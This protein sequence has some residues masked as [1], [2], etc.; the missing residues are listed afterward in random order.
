MSDKLQKQIQQNL[1]HL[2]GNLKDNFLNT[3]RRIS[4]MHDRATIELKIW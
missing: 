2:K 1:P 3:Q 4:I